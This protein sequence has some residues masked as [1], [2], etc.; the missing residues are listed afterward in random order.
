MCVLGSFGGGGGCEYHV[1][2]MKTREVFG[3]D[4]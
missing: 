3:I 4:W 2:E 1:R